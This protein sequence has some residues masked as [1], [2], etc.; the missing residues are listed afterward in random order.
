VLRSRGQIEA[1]LPRLARLERHTLETAQRD[2]GHAGRLREAQIDLCHLLARP[3]AGV[4]Q[5][6]VTCRPLAASPSTGVTVRPS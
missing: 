5:G 3:L 4:A 2:V 6:A 1:D